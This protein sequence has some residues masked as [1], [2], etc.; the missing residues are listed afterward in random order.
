MDFDFEKVIL[1]VGGRTITGYA[2]GSKI[3]AE[4]NEDS[5]E[6]KTGTHGDTLYIKNGNKSG[7]IKCSLFPSSASLPW[8]RSLA[9]AC[10]PVAV[11]LSNANKEGGFIVSDDDCRILKVPPFASEDASELSIHVPTMDYKS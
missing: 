4:R 6:P 2:D 10:E 9:A 7:L 3:S 8:L 11:T 5:V 1:R